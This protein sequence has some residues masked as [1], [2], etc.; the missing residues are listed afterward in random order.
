MKLVRHNKNKLAN[1][2]FLHTTAIGEPLCSTICNSF[3]GEKPTFAA[4]NDE[5]IYSFAAKSLGDRKTG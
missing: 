5:A 2:S 3:V 4:T 1:K